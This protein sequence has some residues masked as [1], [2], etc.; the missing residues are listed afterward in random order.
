[1]IWLSKGVGLDDL[2]TGNTFTSHLGVI[3]K[4]M[5]PSSSRWP[6]NYFR[7]T[8]KRTHRKEEIIFNWLK[9]YSYYYS[10]NLKAFYGSFFYLA[11]LCL[12]NCVS[13]NFL[14]MILSTFK[15]MNIFWLEWPLLCVYM[16]T[17]TFMYLLAFF[18]S[19][20]RISIKSLESTNPEYSCWISNINCYFIV[21]SSKLPAPAGIRNTIQNRVKRNNKRFSN[22][23]SNANHISNFKQHFWRDS[24][25]KC[26]KS[27]FLTNVTLPDCFVDRKRCWQLFDLKCF[28]HDF[29]LKVHLQQLLLCG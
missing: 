5:P 17:L 3:N 22:G 20:H 2:C 28:S 14:I 4:I 7:Y 6:M 12:L 18:S 29:F 23:L 9:T 1:M 21:R 24:G 26:I 27:M 11:W 16:P 15:T 8:D 10:Y 25:V 13:L 19:V